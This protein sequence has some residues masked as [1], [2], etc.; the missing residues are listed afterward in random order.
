MNSITAR[1]FAS[2]LPDRITYPLQKNFVVS[3]PLRINFVVSKD[4]KS[5]IFH[6]IFKRYLQFDP[7]HLRVTVSER[8]VEGAD[9]YHYHRPHLETDLKAP[10]V[11]TVHHDP[12]EMDPWVDSGRF[13]RVYA[14]TARIVCLNS[15]QAADL[16]AAGLENT[17][18]IPHGY[19]SR[20]LSRVRKTFDPQAKLNIGFISKYYGRRVKGDAYLYECLERLP[21]ERVRFTL[22]GTGRTQDAAHIRAMGFEA[23]VFEYLPYRLF[24][25]LYR[26][27]D[28]LMMV[29][30]YEGGPANLPEALASATPVLATRVGM[31]PD[32]VRDGE[33]GM[34]LSGDIRRDADVLDG[35]AHNRDGI[36]ERLFQGAHEAETVIPWEEVIRRHIRLYAE[37][38]A[39]AA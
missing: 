32:M 39:E 6:D 19:D 22:V 17:V 23:D 26:E 11:V 35:I 20:V 30:T 1:D 12:R 18:V 2:T 14:Q 8:P 24:G 5:K 25:A 28:F 10:A 29:S 16:A 36:V 21:P 4:L 34:I 27:L 7:D 3:K 38:I 31:V 37:I 15:L 9:I 13:R 33:N